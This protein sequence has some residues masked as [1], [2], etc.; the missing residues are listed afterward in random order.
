LGYQGFFFY[1][2]ELVSVDELPRLRSQI[3][4]PFLNYVYRPD[5]GA[6]RTSA[7]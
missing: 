3:A 5:C 2:D 6:A 7:A 4:A 1:K